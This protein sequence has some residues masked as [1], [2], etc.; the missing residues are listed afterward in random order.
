MVE[1]LRAGYRAMRPVGALV[2]LLSSVPGWPSTDA[3]HRVVAEVLDEPV[4]AQFPPAHSYTRAFVKALISKAEG[5][6]VE[7]A[8]ELYTRYV[9]FCVGDTGGDGSTELAHCTLTLAAPA[10]APVRSTAPA[11][12]AVTLR[13]S[14]ALNPVGL[15]TW[16]AGYFLTELLI[17][18]HGWLQSAACCVCV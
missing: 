11:P 15:T 3:Q 10:P 9:G 1:E 13:L 12:D 17:H 2:P 6:G 4:V 8:E 7:V 18:R 14:R 5:A 16:P